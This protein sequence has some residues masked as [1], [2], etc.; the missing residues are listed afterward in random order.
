MK[1]FFFPAFILYLFLNPLNPQEVLNGGRFYVHHPDGIK[2]YLLPKL[3]SEIVGTLLYGSKVELFKEKVSSQEEQENIKGYW[4]ELNT[5]KYHGYVL[6]SYLSRYPVPS[7]NC[8]GLQSYMDELYRKQK[9]LYKDE[10]EFRAITTLYQGGNE[11]VYA[12]TKDKKIHKVLLKNAKLKDGF[13]I[14]RACS[15]SG[16]RGISFTPEKSKLE[17]YLENLKNQEV[18]KL[19]IYETSEGTVINYL[20]I[21]KG[22]E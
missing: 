1:K 21:Q 11:H 2:V 22:L 5:K 4:R 12:K 6:D 18:L 13:L 7:T 14:G 16:F 19:E 8:E 9:V 15:H 17:Y 3:D 10:K 20:E